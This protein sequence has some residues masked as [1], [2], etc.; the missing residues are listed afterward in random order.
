MHHHLLAVFGRKRFHRRLLF[1]RHQLVAEA[2][3]SS[4]LGYS[5]KTTAV[6]SALQLHNFALVQFLL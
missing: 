5:N 6:F 4:F 2:K 1:L 3:N